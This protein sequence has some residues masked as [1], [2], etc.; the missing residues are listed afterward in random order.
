MPMIKRVESRWQ[1]YWD[2]AYF[3]DDSLVEVR[4]PD[5]CH[6]RVGTGQHRL[7]EHAGDGQR[8]N[9]ASDGCML[10]G[11]SYQVHEIGLRVEFDDP[12]SGDALHALLRSMTLELVIGNMPWITLPPGAFYPHGLV[13]GTFGVG[14]RVGMTVAEVSADPEWLHGG[15]CRFVPL[16]QR[17]AKLPP[18]QHFNVTITLR[19]RGQRTLTRLQ[20]EGHLRGEMSIILNG[21]QFRDLL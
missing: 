14:G 7:F 15:Y 8:T 21:V 19:G 13:R 5:N 18:F 11:Q 3:D 16:P 4:A 9:M 20:Q 10:A 12:F 6:F 1:P 17:P 2:T